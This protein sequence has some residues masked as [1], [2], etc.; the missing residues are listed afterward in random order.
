M[1]RW[2]IYTDRYTFYSYFTVQ[3]LQ[4][5]DA[6]TMSEKA[7]YRRSLV[8]FFNHYIFSRLIGIA[9]CVNPSFGVGFV[10]LGQ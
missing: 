8:N 5:Y 3:K 1:W 6:D 9:G 7:H 2:F 10:F 4:F